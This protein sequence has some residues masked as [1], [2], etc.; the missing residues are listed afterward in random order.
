MNNPS[1]ANATQENANKQEEM[2][3]DYLKNMETC[4]QQAEEGKKRVENALK[5]KM[6]DEAKQ[7]AQSTSNS[8]YEALN[9]ADLSE[10]VAIEQNTENTELSKL[11]EEISKC[12]KDAHRLAYQTDKLISDEESYKITFDKLLTLL[13]FLFKLG[14][15]IGGGCIF[16]YC[17]FYINYLPSDLGMGNAFVSIFTA[18][19]LGIGYVFALIFIALLLGIGYALI[20]GCPIV[21]NFL[22]EVAR[23]IHKYLKN[24]QDQ[25]REKIKS[26]RSLTLLTLLIVLIVLIALS[27]IQYYPAVK[28]FVSQLPLDSLFSLII[29]IMLTAINL[30][31]II[32]AFQGEFLLD[33]Y[34]P[35]KTRFIWGVIFVILQFPLIQQ[36]SELTGVD[37][38]RNS[39]NNL[40]I[41]RQNVSIEL[42]E[43]DFNLIKNTAE[44]ADIPVLFSCKENEK[45][46]HGVDVLWHGLGENT[47]IEI[48]SK[49]QEKE[50]KNN[51]SQ[52]DKQDKK[53]IRLELKSSENKIITL[54]NQTSVKGC[55]H[56]RLK[57]SFDKGKS[58]P[59]EKMT[60][61]LNDILKKVADNY[62]VKK[63]DVTG[64][65]DLSPYTYKGGN[66]Q[67]SK[68]RA[69]VVKSKIDEI[70]KCIKE[71]GNLEVYPIGGGNYHADNKCNNP[72]LSEKDL[73]DCRMVDRGISLRFHVEQKKTNQGNQQDAQSKQQ[74]N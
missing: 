67:L 62:T 40:G 20:V 22:L 70:K 13:G 36:F 9:I 11:K 1:Q 69:D 29:I 61:E 5:A 58:E 53:Y 27:L 68:Q 63:L 56:D 23:T 74:N 43:K 57:N 31:I 17:F 32:K 51:N 28:G 71:I 39:I 65:A 3:K 66:Q 21:F 64:Y 6:L 37:F 60:K 19:G 38:L 35:S 54:G 44:E 59:S 34:Y 46:I 47:F 24:V 73:E 52:Q 16:I 48:T 25:F 26:L 12:A 42:S 30:V 55:I 4:K 49:A 72:K 18:L 45:T 8:A 50:D 14:L 33:Q 7:H 15:L 2:L 10:K 41:A